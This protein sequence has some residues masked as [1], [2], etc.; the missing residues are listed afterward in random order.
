MFVVK[1]YKDELLSSWFIRLAKVNHTN[2]SSIIKYIFSDN[3]LSLHTKKLHTKDIDLYEFTNE[4]QEILYAQTG[5]KIEN[6]QLFKYSGFLDEK[7]D[8]YKK[9]WVTEVNATK[10]NTKK[11]L[12][13]RFCPK[14]LE[15]KSYIRQLWRIMLYN[16]CAKHK[17]YMLCKCPSCSEKFMYYDNGY[18]RK[19]H[20]CHNC[21]FDLRKAEITYASKI[22]HIKTQSKILNILK[23]G[24]YKLNNRYY[25]SIGLFY[26]L[27]TILLS[28]I[29]T[30]NKKIIYVKQ[31]NPYDLA[32]YISHALFLFEKFPY[33]VNKFY[34]NSGLTDIHNILHW[35]D[36]NTKKSNLPNWYLSGIE[37]NAITRIGKHKG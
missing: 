19:I 1:P 15:E 12:G 37:H 31:L 22:K 16:I 29:H 33:R 11:F 21:G 17:C 24:Y 3:I 28:I 32:R 5:I 34:K 25:Y 14:C 30:K 6:L 13:P 4:Q 35:N 23:V 9:L 2:V 36:R 27:K 7:I 26:L 18:T 8:R 20:V 10:H